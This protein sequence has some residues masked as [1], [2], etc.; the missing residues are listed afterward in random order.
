MHSSISA[1]C[2][3]ST[4][5][6][7]SL[8]LNANRSA[9]ESVL[10]SES[11]N[12]NTPLSNL[13][14]VDFENASGA[15]PNWVIAGGKL[16]QSSNTDPSFALIKNAVEFHRIDFEAQVTI[17]ST[18]DDK[19]GIVF[20]YSD[21]DNHVL[22]RADDQNN[23]LEL[24]TRRFGV[25]IVQDSVAWTGVFSNLVVRAEGSDEQARTTRCRFSG[26]GLVGSTVLSYTNGDG[27]YGGRIGV[28]SEFNN[29]ATF[30]NFTSVH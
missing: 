24:V 13:N 6:D 3:A 26:G 5:V 4:N 9:I 23:V 11:V 22:C 17:N 28:Y 14:E 16:K 25:D 7:S 30:N 10:D 18:D 15:A 2:P 21:P 20:H 29:G 19:A 27:P 8:I 12:I 1:T